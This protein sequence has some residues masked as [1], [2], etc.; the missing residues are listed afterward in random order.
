MMTMGMRPNNIPTLENKMPDVN[1]PGDGM[2]GGKPK[3]V[4]KLAMPPSVM[5]LNKAA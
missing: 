5:I 2:S 4:R 1:A 3:A